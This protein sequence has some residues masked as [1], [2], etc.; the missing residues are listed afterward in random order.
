MDQ[1]W[2]TNAITATTAIVE[3]AVAFA[4]VIAVVIAVVNAIDANWCA[5][6]LINVKC[7]ASFTLNDT[8][9]LASFIVEGISFNIF[10]L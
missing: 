10:T 2:E 4:A 6:A 1:Q 7:V 8:Q 3:T 9:A 5:E